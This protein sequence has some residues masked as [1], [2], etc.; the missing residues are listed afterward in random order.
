MSSEKTLNDVVIEFDQWRKI[1]KNIHAKIPER[2]WKMVADLRS[3]YPEDEIIKKLDLKP[4]SFKTEMAIIFNKSNKTS[5][6][7]ITFKEVGSSTEKK[8]TLKL[9]TDDISY[10]HSPIEKR[11]PI[12][13]INF[14]N[15]VIVR[16][17]Q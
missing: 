5:V 15:G 13:E 17:F 4:S 8:P 16:F 7:D 1:N 10:D 9:T 12:L 14:P 2:L 11:D 6:P 3:Q